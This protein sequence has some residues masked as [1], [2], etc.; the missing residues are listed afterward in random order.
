MYKGKTRSRGSCTG[1]LQNVCWW[2]SLW[3][4]LLRRWW[5]WLP[6]A[7]ELMEKKKWTKPECVRV[8]LVAEEAVLWGCKTAGTAIARSGLWGTCITFASCPTAAS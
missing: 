4:N 1:A 6:G 7:G 2:G 8:T 5:T 3:F